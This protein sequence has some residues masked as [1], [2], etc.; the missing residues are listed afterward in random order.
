[1]TCGSADAERRCD[2]VRLHERVDLV[3]SRV[4][5]ARAVLRRDGGKAGRASGPHQHR[6]LADRLGL[7]VVLARSK[8]GAPTD[9]E[10]CCIALMPRT[11]G[12]PSGPASAS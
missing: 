4:R 11:Y 7:A 2:G 1:M 8:M 12:A 3:R 6:R 9:A 10:A 5:A